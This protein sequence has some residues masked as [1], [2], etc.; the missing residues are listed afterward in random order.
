MSLLTKI[1]NVLGG[2]IFGE[3]KDLLTEY[4]PPDMS[5]EKK[6]ELSERIARLELE[7]QLALHSVAADAEKTLNHRIAEQEGTASDLLQV[8]ILGRIVLFLRGVQRPAWGFFVMHLD[9]QWFITPS[10]KVISGETVAAFTEQQQTALIVI[11]VLV[12]GF[13]FGE[14]TVKNLEP[15]ITKVFGKTSK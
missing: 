4:F 7:K 14:R 15:L 12:L 6:A 1:T 11:N 3:V 2:S 10:M 5:P 8:P 13:L 9:Y